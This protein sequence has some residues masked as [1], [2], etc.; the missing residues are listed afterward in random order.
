VSN[1][2]NTSVA[3]TNATVSA[4]TIADLIK[5]CP[6]GKACGPDKITY[7]HL[8]IANEIR[9]PL[10]ANLFTGML[11]LCYIPKTMKRGSIVTLNKG[12]KT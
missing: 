6:K 8:I 9:S 5:S 7:K 10:L 3:D 11:K 4:T 1:V 2:I 12:G